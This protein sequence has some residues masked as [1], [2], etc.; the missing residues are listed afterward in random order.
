MLIQ[1]GT[2]DMLFDDAAEIAERATA[3]GVSV[4]LEEWVGMFHTWHRYTGVLKG[5]DEAIAAIGEFVRGVWHHRRDNPLR[6]PARRSRPS[7]RLS[8][9]RDLDALDPVT[10]DD[11]RVPA[12]AAA[13]EA[14]P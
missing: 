11:G 10:I 3:A 7:Q 1:I 8:G 13:A 6:R 2:E 12:T 4:R 5:A 9:S 14:A